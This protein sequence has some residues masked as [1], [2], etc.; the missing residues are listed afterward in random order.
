[1]AKKKKS[2]K[3]KKDKSNWGKHMLGE[4]KHTAKKK[5]KGKGSKPPWLKDDDGDDDDGKKTNEA[6]SV[7]KSSKKGGKGKDKKNW[8]KHMLGEEYIDIANFVRCMAEK[9]YA[10]ANKYLHAALE[11]KLKNRIRT[12]A[13]GE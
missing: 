2:T 8:G 6:V 10:E 13:Q 4:K 9:N 12:T 5:K 11:Q 3:S 1:M 7:K